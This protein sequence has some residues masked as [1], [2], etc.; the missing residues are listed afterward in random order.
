MRDLSI[1]S[2]RLSR[3][4]GFVLLKDADLLSWESPDF[5]ILARGGREALV[6]GSYWPTSPAKLALKVG[7]LGTSEEDLRDKLGLLHKVLYAPT[8][9]VNDND[10]RRSLTTVLSSSVSINTFPASSYAEVAFTLS[11][12]THGWVENSS[13]STEQIE[14]TSTSLAIGDVPVQDMIILVGMDSNSKATITCG[15]SMISLD[16]SDAPEIPL[17][18]VYWYK[19]DTSSYQAGRISTDSFWSTWTSANDVSQYLSASHPGFVLTPNTTNNAF[20][21]ISGAT[22]VRFQYYKIWVG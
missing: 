4:N 16:L 3:G 2:V 1:S 5:N 8:V 14:T 20:I 9:N 6:T 19:I 18:S 15:T 22:A 7:V 11:A 13:T 10:L 17:G 12:T 21:T